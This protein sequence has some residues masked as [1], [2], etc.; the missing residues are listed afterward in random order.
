[1]DRMNPLPFMNSFYYFFMC[2]SW[3][4]SESYYTNIVV[5]ATISQK[6]SMIGVEGL[7]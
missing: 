1:M 2:L 3:F 4:D 7:N 6:K 5:F